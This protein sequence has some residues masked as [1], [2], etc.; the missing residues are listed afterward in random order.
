MHLINALSPDDLQRLRTALAAADWQDG[1]A[2]AYGSA[3]QR[4]RNQQVTE[5]DPALGGLFRGLRTFLLNHEPL[6]QLAWPRALLNLRAARYGVGDA[7]GWHVD[8]A[9]MGSQRSDL[10]FTL[11]VSAPDSYQGGELELDHGHHKVRVKGEA[12]QLLVYP[13]GTLHQ[14]C[15][16]TAGERLVVVG[17]IE[18]LVPRADDREMLFTLASELTRLKALIDDPASFDRLNALQQ[19]LIRRLAH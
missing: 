4:K 10:S 3:R 18:S 16:V 17:W 9:V 19:N 15:P 14:V 6:R 5:A 13:T 7:Y 12:G 8:Q 1:T 11:F 2:T